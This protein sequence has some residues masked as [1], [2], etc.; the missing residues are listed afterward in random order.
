MRLLVWLPGKSKITLCYAATVRGWLNAI[1]ESCPMANVLATDSPILSPPLVRRLSAR[2]NREI[3]S[4]DAIYIF[5]AIGNR[6][7]KNLFFN[8]GFDVV[9]LLGNIV[10]LLRR[11]IQD[12][13]KNYQQRVS[14]T[15]RK[16][17][18][19]FCRWIEDFCKFLNKNIFLREICRFARGK[20]VAQFCNA[21]AFEK[22]PFAKLLWFVT[23][24]SSK[25]SVL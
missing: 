15:F 22:F 12:F 25:I 24:E 18:E 4:T 8:S 17:S 11:I 10:N 9:F 20:T 23:V 1:R 2:L 3:P 7:N 6:P 19:I 14:R 13:A 21:N 5:R 16:I